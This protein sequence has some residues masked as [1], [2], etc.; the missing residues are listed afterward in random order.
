MTG[1]LSV[2]QNTISLIIASSV[3]AGGVFTESWLLTLVGFGSGIA[4]IYAMYARGKKDLEQANLFKK[5]AEKLN[6]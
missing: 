4:T 6:D 2:Y 3:T 5:Q 1:H